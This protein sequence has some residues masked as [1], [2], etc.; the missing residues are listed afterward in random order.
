MKSEVIKMCAVLF[1]LPVGILAQQSALPYDHYLVAEVGFSTTTSIVFPFPISAADYGSGEILA[2]P[3]SKDARILKIKAMRKDFIATNITVLTTAGTLYSI[4]VVYVEFPSKLIYDWSIQRDIPGAVLSLSSKQFERNNSIEE[5]A[6]LIET[7]KAKS[8]R[9]SGKNNM[10]FS[11]N[12]IFRQ[13]DIL[14]FK[15]TITN[16]SNI[17]YLVKIVQCFIRDKKKSKKTSYFEKSVEPVYQYLSKDTIADKAVMILA[18][19]Q[20]TIADDKLFTAEL[21]ELNGD[22]FLKLNTKGKSILSAKS[23]IHHKIL[24]HAK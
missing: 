15:Y 1:L 7:T 18:F 3:V 14:F 8:I 21:S 4:P 5:F 23:I 19:N 13:D 2:K 10:A 20:F 24:S 6:K 11:L 17:P 12:D 22:R 16:S 9:S